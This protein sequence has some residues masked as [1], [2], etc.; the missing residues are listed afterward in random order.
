VTSYLPPFGLQQATTVVR[1]FNLL[2]RPALAILR[3]CCSMASCMLAR[4][5]SLMDENS[6]MQHTPL[7]LST[8]APASSWYSP[9]SSLTAA[10]V[11]PAP[12]V[13]RPVV[14][15]LRGTCRRRWWWWWW[16]CVSV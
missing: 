8:S 10:H 15:T 9:P 11:S 14:S 3:V 7:L 2:T 1:A 6:S 16:W 4:S 12:V 13:P 5:D